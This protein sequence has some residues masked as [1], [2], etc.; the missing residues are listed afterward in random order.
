MRRGKRSSQSRRWSR[1]R[2][3]TRTAGSSRGARARTRPYG[4]ENEGASVEGQRRLLS[5]AV[6]GDHEGAVG[7]SVSDDDLLPERLG[8]EVGVIGLGAD[9][10]WIDEYFGPS[11]AVGAGDLGEPLVPAGRQAQLGLAEGEDREGIRAGRAGPEVAVLVVA[12]GDRDVE[13][14]GA[15]DELA[16]G[17]D[18]DRGVEPEPVLALGPLVERGV[19]VG[20]GRRRHLGGEPVGAAARQLLRFGDGRTRPARVDGEVRAQGQLL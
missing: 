20:A 8:V 19:D 17:S 7:D 6:D 10:G 5:E 4:S 3:A 18:D 11:E 9:R 13:L 12:G 16:V 15:G 1:S 14:A 2:S